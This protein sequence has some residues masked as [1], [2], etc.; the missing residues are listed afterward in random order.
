MTCETPFSAPEVKVM[1]PCVKYP[2][3][4]MDG[5]GAPWASGPVCV[6]PV[7]KPVKLACSCSPPEERPT[8]TFQPVAPLGGEPGAATVNSLSVVPV[9]PGWLEPVMAWTPSGPAADSP[10]APVKVIDRKSVV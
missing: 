9:A 10:F 8:Y 7:P 4:P 1:T 2:A 5:G 6:Q 3:V